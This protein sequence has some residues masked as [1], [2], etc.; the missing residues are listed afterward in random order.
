M[1]AEWMMET[2]PW[3]TAVDEIRKGTAGEVVQVCI[4][5]I[6]GEVGLSVDQRAPGTFVTRVVDESNSTARYELVSQMRAS[7]YL[8]GPLLAKRG[9]AKVSLPGG[10]VIGLRPVDLHI[11]GLRALGA[12]IFLL[13]R[14]AYA[15]LYIGGVKILR[16]LAYFGGIAGMVLIIVQLLSG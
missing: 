5:E 8:L 1:K 14:L 7:I 13:S 11:K 4:Q 15:V 3:E 10:C 2:G 6:L 12:E 9:Y 16:S